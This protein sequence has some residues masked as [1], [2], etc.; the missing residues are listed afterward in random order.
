M[1]R[2]DFSALLPMLLAAPALA[3]AIE[4]QTAPAAAAPA[5][6]PKLASGQYAWGEAYGAQRP[7][8]T[9]HRFLI[10]MLPDN[11]RIESHVTFL[12]P[13]TPA[14]AVEHHKHSEIWFVREGTVTLMAGGV[15][16]TL[17]AGEMGLVTAGDDHYITNASK[18]EPASYF[19]LAVGPPE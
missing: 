6:L 18:T 11:I 1:N 12:A 7:A 3:P 9:S 13:G 2:R 17:K 15:I 19:V 8:R 4:A 14:E 16:H 10:G 5:A